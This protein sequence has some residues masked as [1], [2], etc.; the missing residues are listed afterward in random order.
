M[1]LA[2][3]TLVLTLAVGS[4]PMVASAQ[5]EGPWFVDMAV[6]E[7][8]DSLGTGRG[9][10]VFDF[11]GDGWIDVFQTHS[12]GSNALYRNLGNGFVDVTESSGVA[13]NEFHWGATIGDYDN[14]G[15]PD[16]YVSVGGFE[17]SGPN[18]LFRNDGNVF[19]EVAEE[20]GVAGV[21]AKSASPVWLDYDLDGY[22]DLFVVN[23]NPFPTVQGEELPECAQHVVDRMTAEGAAP[24]EEVEI[25]S[26]V[27][28]RNNQDG[29]FTDV[30][31]EAGLELADRSFAVTTGDYD[32]DGYVD[33]YVA[34]FKGPNMLYRNLG[35]GTFQDVAA[36]AGGLETPW[37]SMSPAFADFDNDGYLDLFVGTW[38]SLRTG[39]PDPGEPNYLFRNL[40]D[41]TFREIA[42]N[43]GVEHVGG[44]MGVQVADFDLDG[45]LDI[46]LGSGGPNPSERQQ[47][48][49]FRNNGAGGFNEVN[50]TTS[51]ID[52]LFM[53]HGVA[54]ADF[55]R[56]GDLDFFVGNGGPVNKGDWSNQP[57]RLYIN[58]APPNNSL[59]LGFRGETSNR[60]GLGVIVEAIG[61]G[62]NQRRELNAGS[63]FASQN[64]LEVPLGFG[65]ATSVDLVQVTW[66]S[67]IQQSLFDV[68]MNRRA[69]L[70][71]PRVGIDIDF[72]LVPTLGEA[73]LNIDLLN[74]GRTRSARLEVEIVDSERR[75]VRRFSD[76]NLTL[77]PG[78]IRIA[79]DWKNDEGLAGRYFALARLVDSDTGAEVN[80]GATPLDF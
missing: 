48:L 38:N 13:G 58:I 40:G 16:I 70:H 27:L 6:G 18:L 2:T 43:A 76:R 9:T 22:L 5:P 24:P 17:G 29:T 79:L 20:V 23:Y 15:D 41:G 7:G 64:G 66:P 75:T 73:L 33:L 46:Y 30:T 3:S 35:D 11:D 61:N 72:E 59:T 37:A 68:E 10:A 50:S 36:A 78:E 53:A 21:N 54:F 4:F 51:G 45:W 34:S 25:A 47:D 57:N 62:F 60:S 28:Y 80:L 49:L 8:M 67:G 39:V 65:L 63:G 12:D 55:D 74:A 42:S 56:D 31:I 44:H 71:E 26:N 32:Q 14:D 52:N 77:A 69:T 19:T 1:K